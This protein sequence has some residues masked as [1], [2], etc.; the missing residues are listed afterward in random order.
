M[1][2]FSRTGGKKER[3]DSRRGE[4]SYYESLEES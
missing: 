3:G 1:K 4:E 2:G